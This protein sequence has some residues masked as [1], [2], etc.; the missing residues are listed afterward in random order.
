MFT[1]KW[2]SN[3]DGI[4]ISSLVFRMTLVLA[5]SKTVQEIE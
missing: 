5:T 2:V 3:G 1:K 4:C